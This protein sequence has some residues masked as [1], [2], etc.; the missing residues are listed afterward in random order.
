VKVAV[1]APSPY[2]EVAAQVVAG[3]VQAGRPPCGVLT[4]PAVHA[5][6]LLRKSMQLGPG[7]FVRYAARRVLGGGAKDRPA[8]NGGGASVAPLPE[9]AR[10]AGV[11]VVKVNDINSPEAVAALRA[12][13]ADAAVYTGGGIVRRAL[14]DALPGGILNAHLALLPRIRGMSSP[15]WSLL[16]GVPLGVTVH[17]MDTGI[18]TGPVLLERRLPEPPPP[19][20]AQVRARLVALG[21]EGLLEALAGMAAGTL[22]PV[23]QA[24][25]GRDHQHFVVHERLRALAEARLQGGAASLPAAPTQPRRRAG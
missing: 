16:L 6:T 20:L 4:L 22:E 12:W 3:L 19:S 10:A 14:L 9:L 24:E 18:D 15:E 21:V 7:T 17:L 8:E 1:L 2:S 25:R 13:G 23:E 5:G 11:P